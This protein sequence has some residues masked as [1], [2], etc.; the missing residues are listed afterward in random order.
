MITLTFLGGVVVGI[1]CTWV[2]IVVWVL[3][4]DGA[5]R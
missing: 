1:A 2:G 4:H 5:G 3:L